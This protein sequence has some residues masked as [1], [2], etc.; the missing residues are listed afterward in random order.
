MQFE[1]AFTPSSFFVIYNYV[2]NLVLY[3]SDA[4]FFLSKMACRSEYDINESHRGSR[5]EPLLPMHGQ[6]FS[7]DNYQFEPLVTKTEDVTYLAEG[8]ANVVFTINRSLEPPMVLRVR[9]AGDSTYPSY[10]LMDFYEHEVKRMFACHQ[11]L[12]LKLMEMTRAII[13]NLNVVISKAEAEGIRPEKR[14]GTYIDA[15]ESTAIVLPDMRARGDKESMIEFKPKWLLQSPSAPQGSL[16]CRT[17]ALREM[18]ASDD[19]K[20]GKNEKQP[21]NRPTAFCPFDLLAS[22]IE[23]LKS[24]AVA[25]GAP[26]DKIDQFAN[27]LKNNQTIQ[28]LRKV[29]EL[30]NNVGLHHIRKHDDMSL[31]MSIRDCTIFIKITESTD[32]PLIQSVLADMDMKKLDGEHFLKWEKTES[33][34]I[35]EGWY[36]GTEGDGQSDKHP[37]NLDLGSVKAV[38]E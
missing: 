4:S 28:R 30:R 19:R 5:E 24:V 20:Q 16:R 14:H 18:R 26:N 7:D 33:R 9:K 6:P 12:P 21:S 23:V 8:N 38:Q 32:G 15:H 34:L 11:I 25:V 2:S 31:S 17:C 3:E 35:S 37:C 36:Q 1:P 29:Q 10:V 13:Q 27:A 22:N